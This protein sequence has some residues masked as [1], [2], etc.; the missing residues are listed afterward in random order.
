MSDTAKTALDREF[1]YYQA[2]KKELLEQY[3]GRFIAIKGEAV[4]GV[5]DN[6]LVAIKATMQDHLLGTFLV[7]EVTED[8][9]IARFHSRVAF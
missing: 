5:F 4:I 1:A 6:R 9:K 2:H 7:Q 8:D 3:E